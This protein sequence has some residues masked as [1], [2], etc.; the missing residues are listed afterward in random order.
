MQAEQGTTGPVAYDALSI[1]FHWIT[2]LLVT[3]LF[4]L[5]LVPGVVKGSIFLHKTLGI[6]LFFLVLLRLIWRLS[7][8]RRP[9]PVTTEPRLLRLA[10]KAAHL[11]LYGLLLTAPVL[12]W[13]YLDAKAVDIHPY[14]VAALE[15]PS[16]L[17]Y[18]R[19]LAMAIY[20]VKKV[21]V[22][23]LLALILLHAAAAL[24][25]HTLIRKDAVL[26][27]ILPSRWRGATLAA[28]SVVSLIAAPN[29][30]HAAFDAETF[31]AELAASLAKSCPMA[32]AGDV[33][34]HEACRKNIGTG[35]EKVMREDYILFGGQQPTKTW[36]KDKKT[37]VFRGDLYQDMYMSLYMYT[38]EYRV[39]TA[40][41]GLTTI[42]L[43]AYFRNQMPP[44]RYPYPFWH[45][46]AKW[47]AY[48]NSNEMRFR[49]T[50]NGRVVFAYR[51]DIGSED[52]RGPYEKIVR[53]T[54]LGSEWMWRDDSGKAQ[55]EITLFSENYSPDNPNVG[56]IDGA[57]RKMALNFRDANC[58]GCH[59]PEGHRNMNKLT[60][61]Q[62]PFHAASAIDA[63]LDEVRSGKMPV[64]DYDDPKPLDPKLKTE[65]LSNGEAFRQALAAADAW[66]R[67]N[68]RPKA[69]PETPG[70]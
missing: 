7:F 46:P 1:A 10:A 25:Y 44:G 26:R 59:M 42:G 45:S 69:R 28:L 56:N 3:A 64:D 36:L 16:V 53:P 35:I 32:P 68:N 29:A 62:T 55:P 14:G 34:A 39:Q 51:A 21:V 6:T 17:Y 63:V 8:G 38:G 4:A 20:E 50:G 40:P 66:E 67:S 47:D 60:L 5:A 48:Q 23:G 54:F 41:D 15:L 61:L 24:V 22:Y 52:N 58:T 2:F 11:A 9:V 33:E 13:L 30:G 57:Y 19:P 37:S 70:R 27:S 31:A 65:L 49:I 18:D 43:Q 12:G